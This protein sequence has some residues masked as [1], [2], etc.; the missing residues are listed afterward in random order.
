V[1][2]CYESEPDLLYISLSLLSQIFTAVRF[3][4]D[5]AYAVTFERIDPLYTVD[6]S[7]PNDIK[8]LGE[9]EVTGFSEYLHPIEGGKILAVGQETDEDGQIIGL[10]I[11]LFGASDPTELSLINRLRLLNEEH[12]STS[13][14]ASWEPRAF[15]YFTVG[16]LGVLIIPVTKWNWGWRKLQEDDIALE[17]DVPAHRDHFDGFEVFT[18]QN[19]VI[20]RYFTI[21]HHD[22][23]NRGN[24]VCQSWCGDLPERSFVMD[25]DL[26][27]MKGQSVVSTD[28]N[29]QRSDWFINMRQAVCCTI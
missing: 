2:I 6:L 26:I 8:V 10:Q 18:I 16:D 1:K 25:G 29:T 22:I 4:D 14:G 9:L 12:G 24:G 19:D 20:S 5:I 27:T 21:D 13:S 28:L 23:N 11:S 15:R 17:K 3:L 7:N